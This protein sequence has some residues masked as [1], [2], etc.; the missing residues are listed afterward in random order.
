MRQANP[1]DGQSQSAPL[2]RWMGERGL[3]VETGETTLARFMQLVSSDLE[4]IEDIIPADESLLLILKPGKQPSA[5]LCSTLAAPA[6]EQAASEGSLHVLPVSPGGEAGPDLLL[7]AAFVGLS[8][9]EFVRQFMAIEFTVAF[10]G[11]QPGFPYLSGLPD[12][13]AMPRRS[14]PRVRVPAGSVALGGAYAGVYP[15]AGPG[16]W[17]IVGQTDTRLF[18]PARAQPALLSAGDRVRFE[19]RS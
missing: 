9:S 18:D 6:P 16:G 11:F 13:W 2:W 12:H 3:R 5:R 8:A 17:H 15:A 14:T 4:E 1:Q 19:V 7:C 10:L